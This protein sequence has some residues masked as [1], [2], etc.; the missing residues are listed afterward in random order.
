MRNNGEHRLLQFALRDDALI[1][2][3]ICQSATNH[4]RKSRVENLDRIYI[5]ASNVAFKIGGE[6]ED[7][8]DSTGIK[9]SRTRY[10]RNG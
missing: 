2:K 7:S 4:F 10:S 5:A 1:E 9:N 6:D 8:R 3:K